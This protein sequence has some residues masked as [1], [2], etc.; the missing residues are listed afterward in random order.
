MTT[1]HTSPNRVV[2]TLWLRV[3]AVA[4]PVLLLLYGLLRLVDG[5]D[6]DHGPGLAWDIGH[7]MFFVAFLLLGVVTVSLRGMVPATSPVRRIVT[8][9]ATV[10]GLVGVAAFLWVILGD[11]SEPIRE[12]APLPDPLYA[13]GPLLF[14]LGVLTL[15]V[16]LATLRPRRLPVWSPVLVFLGF[17]PIAVN[18]D[19]LP[20]G[21][22]LILAGLAPLAR[23]A[24]SA[25]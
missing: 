6:G 15:L 22:L 13:A 8:G 12:Q 18:L 16:Q 25:A 17:V 9:T 5:L 23:R 14:Q 2:S 20:L 10:A 24:G 3:S 11:L 7:T 1:L 19:L 4:A 21:A